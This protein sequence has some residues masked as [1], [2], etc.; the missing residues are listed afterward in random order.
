MVFEFR[1]LKKNSSSDS[2]DNSLMTGIEKS[3]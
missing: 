3:F 2:D 1:K